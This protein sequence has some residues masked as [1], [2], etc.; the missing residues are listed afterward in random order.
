M[1]TNQHEHDRN[2]ERE[3]SPL[4]GLNERQREAVTAPEGPT[5]VLAGPGSGKTTVICARITHLVQ[6]K[7]VNPKN[8][9]AITF[10]R[11]AAEEM[12][13]RVRDS[14]G[15]L[16]GNDVWVSTFHRMCSRILRED[17]DRVGIPADFR[18]ASSNDKYKMIREAAREVRGHGGPFNASGALQKISEIKNNLKATDDPKEWGQGGQATEMA[19]IAGKYQDKLSES[20]T[21]DFDDMMLWSIRLLHE[22]EDVAFSN[23]DR[24]PHLLVDEYQDTNLPQYVLIRQLAN[25]QNNVFVVGDPDQAI[26]EWRGANVENIMRFEEDFAGARRIDLNMTYRSSGNILEAAA[27]LIKPNESRIEREIQT[28]HDAGKP[29]QLHLTS[30]PRTE[31]RYATDVAQQ[32]Y[33]NDNGSVAVLYRTNAQSRAME[34]AFKNA[35][36]PYKIAG[37]ESFY[38]RR[39]VQDML[40]CV[41]I[42]VNKDHAD[43]A[44][45][46][47][48]DMAPG[49]R[50]SRPG[51]SQIEFARGPGNSYRDK[52]E[53]AI[54]DG[55]LTPRDTKIAEG[56]LAKID[57]MQSWSEHTPAQI[58]MKAQDLTGYKQALRQSDDKRRIDKIENIDELVADAHE[59]TMEAR[60]KESPQPS[61]GEIA[62]RFV[63]HCT[64]LQK[65]AHELEDKR[66][67]VT[68]STLHAAKGREFDTVVFAGFDSERLPH[69][70][71]VAEARNPERAIEEERRLAYVGMTRARNELHLTVPLKIGTGNGTKQV[72]RSPFIDAIPDHVI[73]HSEPRSSRSAPKPA[74][75]VSQT[76]TT[77]ARTHSETESLAAAR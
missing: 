69:H 37:G 8:I 6:D 13:D 39:E 52:I 17:G 29:V 5:L 74:S 34:S 23:Q 38:E 31:A 28:T 58:M 60:H 2:N 1:D 24:Y 22:H 4:A 7:G 75:G 12:Q 32:R 14:L 49:E 36:I 20:N 35:S 76:R 65:A 73:Q 26:Y 63:D 56:R 44:A 62:E 59:F 42:A 77:E 18:I 21:L 15:P 11:K 45:E 30:N 53:T 72:S 16:Y 51:L 50:L 66:E 19:E 10:T 68:L 41:E 57:A 3:D 61:N 64:S 54:E 33:E 9:A 55:I 27:A 67:A 48:M 47:F 71:T 43:D 25:E 46:R 40:A 70:R